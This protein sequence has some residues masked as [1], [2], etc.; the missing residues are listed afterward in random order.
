M[1]NPV[2]VA[3]KRTVLGKKVK[4]LR[5]EGLVPANVY[6]KSLESTAIQV[7]QQDFEKIYKEVGE[8]GLVDLQVNGE[9]K[10]VLIKN[11]Q[12]NYK[13]NIPLHVDF[14]QVN[15][16]EKVKTMV[17]LTL[18]GE[19][20]AVTDQIGMLLQTISEVEVE[21]LPDKL[22]DQIE[23]PVEHLAALDEAILVSNLKVPADVTILSDPD[24]T[25]VK[26]AELVVEEPEPVA[27][28]AEGTEGEETAAEG[29]GKA[30]GGE[31]S[32]KP[33]EASEKKEE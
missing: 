4:K 17:P 10:P 33:E 8:T 26:I 14:Y 24:Q 30:E 12:M 21:A 9:N 18:V 29:E 11:L 20:K 25:V 1:K 3:E 5:R 31:E 28:E 6:G 16:K 7:K 22:P 13:L 2:L 32:G 27:E 23:V 15:L 19:P